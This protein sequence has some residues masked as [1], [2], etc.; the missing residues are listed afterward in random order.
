M[1]TFEENSIAFLCVSALNLLLG[2]RIEKIRFKFLNKPY[3]ERMLN[4]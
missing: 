2:Y 1:L 3:L 4:V